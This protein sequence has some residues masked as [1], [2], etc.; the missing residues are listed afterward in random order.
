MA[1]RGHPLGGRLRKQHPAELRE[2][3]VTM[4]FEL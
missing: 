3:A 2:R 4:V 1:G